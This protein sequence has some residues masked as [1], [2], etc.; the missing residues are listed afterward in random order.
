[1][2]SAIRFATLLALAALTTGCSAEP[3]D[4]TSGDEP[5]D[6]A[7]SAASK[8]R[9]TRLKKGPTDRD[10]ASLYAAGTTFEHAFVG[11][12]RFN[13]PT[14]ESTDPVARMKRVK[15]VMHRYMCSLF[16]ESIDMTHARGVRDLKTT[17]ANVN[18]DGNAPDDEASARAFSSALSRVLRNRSL[19]VVSGTASGNNT[20]G[21]IM[22]V[23]DTAHHE[24][25]YFG[26]TN[27]GSDN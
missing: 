4:D 19:D 12:Y 24:V 15:E 26:F 9:F 17:I 1:M 10:L 25:L 3:T 16:D 13:K 14:T 20:M 5:V 11:T 2:T 8:S 21:E 18:L 22:G 27:C 6:V 7:E 23:Y